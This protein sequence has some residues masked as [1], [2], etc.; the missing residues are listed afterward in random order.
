VP[1]AIYDEVVDALAALAAK[2]P[3]GAGLDENGAGLDENNA[4]G[5]LQNQMQWN[6]VNRIVEDA[7]ARGARV[8]MGGDPDAGRP[9]YCYPKTLIAD[10]D[11]AAPLVQEEQFGPALPII[12][13][14]DLEQAVEWA[15]GVDRP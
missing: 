11:N 7:K 3:M 2:I 6:V 10:I 12:R 4:L 5:L 14:T 1:D 13:Y 15:N 9:G 8:V